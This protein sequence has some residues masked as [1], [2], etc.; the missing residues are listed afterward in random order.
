[1]GKHK[2]LGYTLVSFGAVLA[3]AVVAA[4]A[5]AGGLALSPQL[6]AVAQAADQEAVIESSSLSLAE[7]APQ[8]DVALATF[9]RAVI[10]IYQTT[11]P[12]VVDVEVAQRVT[13]GI[14]DQFGQQPEDLFRRGEGSGFVWDKE[15][16]I[17]TNYHVVQDTEVVKVSFANGVSAEAEVIGADADADLAV[18]KV[19]LPASELQ[20]LILGDSDELQV[21]QLTFAIG[22]PFGQDFTMTTGIVSAVERTIRSGNSSFSIPEVIQTDASINPGNSGGPL[23]NRFGEV[24]GIN[25]MI[26]S[27]SGSNAGVGFAVPINIAKQIVPTLIAGEDFEYA[28]LGIIGTSLTKDVTEAMNLT[29][30]TQGALIISVAQNSPAAQ[31]GL[32]GSQDVL[33]IAGQ[34]VPYGGDIITAIQEEPIAD[35]DD[36]ITYLVEKTRPGDQVSLSLIRSGGEAENVTVTLGTRPED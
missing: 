14:R 19:D 30:D 27:E 8:S 18:L 2:I 36:L 25:T 21:G 16:H 11:L 24:I 29:D 15:G 3:L 12:S 9:E 23:L 28:W 35:M 33:T 13:L 6:Y 4:L 5:F 1:M 22:N 32:R 34:E 20:P 31:A 17:V 26:I 10:G 7:P